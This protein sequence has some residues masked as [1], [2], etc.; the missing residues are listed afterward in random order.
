[1]FSLKQAQIAGGCADLKYQA[2]ENERRAEDEEND[3]GDKQERRSELV[4]Y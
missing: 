1:M 4:E 2:E 3:I